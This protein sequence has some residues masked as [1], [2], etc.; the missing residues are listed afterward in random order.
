MDPESLSLRSNPDHLDSPADERYRP[1]FA[2]S[3]QPAWV[4]DRE[5]LRFLEVNE[6][7]VRSYGWTRDEFLGMSLRD[8]RPPSEQANLDDDTNHIFVSGTPLLPAYDDILSWSSIN[9]LFA[10]MVQ[11]GKLP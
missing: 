7:A 1:L 11:A 3:P 5:T 6:A 4:Y 10:R 9:I 8:I 2:L